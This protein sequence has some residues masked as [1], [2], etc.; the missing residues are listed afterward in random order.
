V[1]SVSLT[2]EQ[3]RVGPEVAGW[4]VPAGDPVVFV[5]EATTEVEHDVL[6]RWLEE[7]RPPETAASDV[8]L[9]TFPHPRNGELLGVGGLLARLGMPDEPVIAPL[10]VTW[11]PRQRLGGRV[12][13]VADLLTM[14]DPRNPSHREQHRIAVHDPQRVIVIVGEPATK[15]ELAERWQ[16]YS[17]SSTDDARGFA[18][19][20]ARQAVIT[21]ER[22]EARA[23]DERHK[24]PQHVKEEIVSSGRFRDG[25][26]ALA[27]ELGRPREEVDAE[28]HAYLDEM[29]S[30]RSR[31]FIDFIVKLGKF[32]YEQGYE[33]IDYEQSQVE[34]VREVS[35]HKGIVVLPSHK[36]NLD[37]MV[38]PIALHE[39][40]LPRTHTLAG[41]NMAFWP[42][43]PLSRRAG[44]IFIRRETKDNPVYRW[45]LREYV[46]FLIEKRFGLQWYPEG[47]RSRTGKLLPPKLGLMVY[48]AD[49]YRSGRIDDVAVV[50]ASIVYDQLSEVSDFVYESTGGTKKPEGLKWVVGYWRKLRGRYGKVYIRF[51]EPLSLRDALGPPGVETDPDAARLQLQKLAFEIMWRINHV[52]PITGTALLT[53]V[54]LGAQGR[55]ITLELIRAALDDFLDEARRRQLPMASSADAL[56]TE[57]GAV[58][59]LHALVRS[60]V[61]ACYDE[62]HETVY[63]IGP[64]QHLAAAFYR[65]SIIHFFLRSAISELALV[66]ASEPDVS[67]AVAEFWEEA[68]RLRDL[69]KFEFFFA[70]KDEFQSLMGHELGLRDSN[71]QT[72]VSAGPDEIRRLLAD[73]RPLTAH[74][75][76]R[77]FLEAYL[78]VA[79]ALE[80][81]GPTAELDDRRFL[82]T[83]QA[84]GRQFLLQGRVHNAESVSRPLF[85]N[86]LDLARNRGLIL[87]APAI[88]DQRRAFT[89]E[90]NATIRRVDTVE[91]ASIQQFLVLREERGA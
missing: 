78:V 46:A 62:G 83:C 55:A 26:T 81:M 73:L 76:L 32:F 31:T 72:R 61:V 42:I 88:T 33:S 86:A 80:N 44:V 64:D 18:R 74:T 53:L 67:D 10:R 16:R 37:A 66:R 24:L 49:A 15:A 38:M 36:S 58:A 77:S 51:A 43:G 1:K 35:R 89:R 40:R 20:V 13:A 71:W 57:E 4:P 9:I 8:E 6:E 5:A 28:V 41:I 65:N 54:L 79:K 23:V 19:Y 82:A 22:A 69:L 90:L 52:T 14:T 60:N 87:P 91:T 48:V 84:L 70:E 85:R 2:T 27:E 75:V 17:G 45:T 59:A 25:V 68:L 34:R 7:H 29:V 39:N 30:G 11:L 50:P 56:E 47:T 21:L 63:R 3:R 12:G